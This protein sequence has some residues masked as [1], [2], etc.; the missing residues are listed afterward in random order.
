MS[1]Y[2]IPPEARPFHTPQVASGFD[3]VFVFNPS[4][5]LIN[6]LQKKYS[7]ISVGN[8]LWQLGALP[9]ADSSGEDVLGFHAAFGH[10]IAERDGQR[11]PGL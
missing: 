9:S 4:T 5:Q 6:T 1:C 2:S 7:L 3:D 10:Q 8:D 11:G